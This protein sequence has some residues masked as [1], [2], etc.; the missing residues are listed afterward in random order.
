MRLP[1]GQ[2][3]LQQIKIAHKPLRSDGACRHQRNRAK[4]RCTA[5]NGFFSQLTPCFSPLAKNCTKPAW[6]SG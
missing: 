3:P 5:F 2:A 4:K 6:I 1:Y